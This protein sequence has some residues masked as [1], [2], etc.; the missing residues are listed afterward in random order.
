MDAS[1]GSGALSAKMS[2]WAQP[3]ILGHLDFFVSLGVTLNSA[4][5]PFAKTPFSWLL[6]EDRKTLR[7]SG[8]RGS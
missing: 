6:S 4:E 7:E 8:P 1:F 3:N 2:S 5:T